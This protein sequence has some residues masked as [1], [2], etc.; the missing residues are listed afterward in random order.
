MGKER[1][2]GDDRGVTMS[3]PAYYFRSHVGQEFE[4]DIHN[5]LVATE[6]S[7][8]G[9][10]GFDGNNKVALLLIDMQCDFV[11]R[12]GALSVPGAIKD[13]A[14]VIEWIYRNTGDITKIYASMDTH[15]FNHVFFSSY[16]LDPNGKRP[17]PFTV[18]SNEDIQKERW[19]PVNGM[20][21]PNTYT[22]AL[23]NNHNKQ[24]MIW[25][26][27]ALRGTR[28]HTIAPSLYEAIA[29]HSLARQT[30]PEY[31]IKGL[32]P[33]TEQYSIF[34]PCVKTANLKLNKGLLRE[35]AMYNKVYIAGEAKSHCVLES[36]NSIVTY[37]TNRL[38]NPLQ[39][40][41]VFEDAMSNIISSDGN[42]Q[43]Q[44]EEK[45]QAFYDAGINFTT[46]DKEMK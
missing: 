5:V 17:E 29:Y 15:N 18:I 8:A 11:F 37:F 14:N 31:I 46:T 24:L 42:G 4:P 16:W 44:V 40:F 13:C 32:H 20:D 33:H 26:Y 45:F 23:E 35:L 28:G 1:R 25:P 21:W 2:D 6:E 39:R 12:I 41:F 22:M 43:E 19:I 7:G 10:Y 34:E 9:P 36:I 27:H 3:F 38:G 30:A